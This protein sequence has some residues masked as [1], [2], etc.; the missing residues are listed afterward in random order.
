MVHQSTN[1]IFE[2][3]QFA[4]IA[5]IRQLAA[6]FTDC[7]KESH[8]FICALRAKHDNVT[9]HTY[10]TAGIKRMQ[11]F[12]VHQNHFA[13]LTVLHVGIQQF[14]RRISVRWTANVLFSVRRHASDVTSY[15]R[16]QC[17]YHVKIKN[18]LQRILQVCFRVIL[19]HRRL[20]TIV[21]LGIKHSKKDFLPFM[22]HEAPATLDFQTE[23]T[24]CVCL[25]HWY[26]L[27]PHSFK[28]ALLL[29]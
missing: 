27:L 28:S 2:T 1:K 15:N 25:S 9:N 14:L 13:T 23:L 10:R 29:P 16:L 4:C 24:Q 21:S 7:G 11:K 12:T 3:F 20:L 8:I 17:L 19:I 5:Y 22:N 6:I 26:C 18:L